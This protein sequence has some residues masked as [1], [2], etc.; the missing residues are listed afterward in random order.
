MKLDVVSRIQSI[1]DGYHANCKMQGEEIREILKPFTVPSYAMNF[2]QE[3]LRNVIKADMDAVMEAWKKYDVILNQKTKEVVASA[4]VEIMK[5]LNVQQGKRPDDYAIRI[6]NAREFLKIELEDERYSK[7]V[8]TPDEVKEADETM[9][10][11]VKEFVSDYDTMKLFFKMVEKKVSV[12]T[13]GADGSCIFPST[14][15]QMM[16]MK[17]IMQTIDEMEATASMIFM[18]DR[19]IYDEVIRIN[20]S[21]FGIP[22]DGYS[23]VVDEQSIIENATILEGLADAI[24]DDGHGESVGSGQKV[25]IDGGAE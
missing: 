19:A 15:G 4:K 16:K 2:T 22:T 1:I 25:D 18:H 9:F 12:P 23:Q 13:I 3:G 14:F 8:M 17:S 10:S 21:S 5:A 7:T 6:A 24:H 11:I 20:G